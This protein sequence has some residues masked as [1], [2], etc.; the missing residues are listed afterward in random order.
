MTDVK[1]WEYAEA[2]RWLH[3]VEEACRDGEF[4]DDADACAFLGAWWDALFDYLN[5]GAVF[6][7]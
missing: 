5:Q 3:A 2:E 1:T 6:D 7:L 4:E